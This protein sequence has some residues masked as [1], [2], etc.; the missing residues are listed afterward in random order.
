[1]KLSTAALMGLLT[2]GGLY[3]ASPFGDDTPIRANNESELINKAWYDEDVFDPNPDA[4]DYCTA[5]VL[6]DDEDYGRFGVHLSLSFYRFQRDLLDYSVN[7][8]TVQITFLQTER[9]ED[10]AYKT[11]ECEDGE[12]PDLNGEVPKWCAV[13]GGKKF[14]AFDDGDDYAKFRQRLPALARV[15]MLR[16]GD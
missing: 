13:I 6:F 1:M 2:V 3:L 16:A 5:L 14:Y 9:T 12:A 11:W 4:R 15:G 10:L 8:K 7:S